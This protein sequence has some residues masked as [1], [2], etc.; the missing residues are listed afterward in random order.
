M[1]LS[2]AIL[3]SSVRCSA[4]PL[5][6]NLDL[7][8]TA[9]NLAMPASQAPVGIKVGNVVKTVAPGSAVTPAEYVA[10]QQMLS[11]GSQSLVVTAAGAASGGSF[12]TSGLGSLS[13]ADLIVP[14][15]VMAVHDFGMA[16]SLNIAGT[17]NNSGSL[18]GLS[19]NTAVTAG[20]INA[21]NIFNNLGA[22]IA[23]VRN[24]E[25]TLNAVKNIVNAGRIASAGNL[26][27]NAGGTITNSGVIEAINGNLNINS[28][29]I[30]NSGGVL[31]A[32]QGQINVGNVM[33]TVKADLHLNGG[34]LIAK[35]VNLVSKGTVQLDVN[36]L[37][38]VLNITAGAAHVAAATSNL[39]LGKM[40]IDGDPTYFNRSGSV[41]LHGPLQ[42][43]GQ[44]LAIVARDDIVTDTG[45]GVISTASDTQ[46]G[47]SILMVAGAEFTTDGGDSGEGV[48]N[49]TLTITGPSA[50]GGQINLAGTV[51]ITTLSSSK[52]VNPGNGGDI[53]L[54]AFG[55][56]VTLPS[57]LV[58]QTGGNGS[59][60]NGSVTIMAG[61]TS[62]TA[63][64]GGAVDTTGGTGGG[65]NVSVHAVQPII[66][67]S[68]VVAADGSIASGT[69]EAGDVQPASVQMGNINSSGSLKVVAGN[70]L[71]VNA[72]STYTARAGNLELAAPNIVLGDA[73]TIRNLGAGDIKFTSAGLPLP[74]TVLAPDGGTT[75]ISTAGGSIYFTPTAGQSLDLS[76]T[77]GSQTAMLNLTGGPVFATVQAGKLHLAENV[78]LQ[79]DGVF[80]AVVET[81]GGII[82]IAFEPFVGTYNGTT[83]ASNAAS[84]GTSAPADQAFWG[85]WMTLSNAAAG[86][87]GVAD[88][89]TISPTGGGSSSVG[90][91][92]NFIATYGQGTNDFSASSPPA[93]FPVGLMPIGTF[94]DV[95]TGAPCGTPSAT[96]QPYIPTANYWNTQA[97]AANGMKIAAGVTALGLNCPNGN[98]IDADGFNTG[99]TLLEAQNAINIA[100]QYPGTVTEVVIGNEMIFG[101]VTIG[102]LITVMNQAKAYRDSQGFQGT[103]PTQ[104]NYLPITTRQRWDVLAGI[105]NPNTGYQPQLT[106]LLTTVA[107]GHVYG[108]MY[109]YFDQI[110]SLSQSAT[111]QNTT[112][113]QFQSS[114]TTSMTNQLTAW[115]NAF[116][117]AGI[118]LDMRIG[119]TGWPT[120]GAGAGGQPAN[121]AN[122]TF[123]QWY[124]QAMQSW[125]TNTTVTGKPAISTIYFEGYDEP[126]KGPPPSSSLLSEAYF[127]LFT[128][129]GTSANNAPFGGPG[130]TITGIT[131]KFPISIS[132][133]QDRFLHIEGTIRAATVN[134]T[135]DTVKN[136]GEI[137][138]LSGNVL[139]NTKNLMN[140]GGATIATNL[141]TGSITIQSADTLK[142]TGTGS[143]SNPAGVGGPITISAG[144]S[145]EFG[146]GASQQFLGGDNVTIQSPMVI[147]PANSTATISTDGGA[148]N[149]LS[150]LG[151]GILFSKTSGTGLATLSLAGGPVS[152]L[153]QA[154]G[155]YVD[156]GVELRSDNVFT[157]NVETTGGI[158]G[159]AFQPFVGVY[160]GNVL[161]SNA[162][163][164]GTSAPAGQGFWGSWMTLSNAAGGSNGVTDLF[165]IQPTLPGG[166]N[167]TVVKNFGFIATYGQGTNDFS[168]SSPPA[169]HAVPLM[170]IGTLY[171]VNTGAPCGSLS[172]TCQAYIPT[173]NYWNIQAA[174]TNGMKISAGVNTI[175]LQCPGGV[176]NDA[177]GFNKGFTL[178][179][180]KHAIDMAKKYPGT[181]SEL[182]I[183][184]EMIFGPVTI[185]DLIT[186]MNQA[187]TYRDQQGF[188]GTDPTRANYLPITTRQKWD[189]LAGVNNHGTGYQPQLKSLLQ[190]V[191]EGHV[192]G[193]MYAYFDPG[194]SL[195]QNATPTNTTKTQFQTSVTTSMTSQLSAW[196]NS[197]NGEG[198][199]IEKRIGET[200]W[201]SAGV[202][203][204]GQ[205]A[206]WGN[207]DFAKWYFEAMQTWTTN[208]TVSGVP[209]IKAIYFEGFDEPIKGPANGSLSE[210]HF[211]LFTA[212]GTSGTNAPFGAPGFTITGIT[213]KFPF[214]LSSVESRLLQVNG[215]IEANAVNLM[216]QNAN[217]NGSVTAT[218]GNVMMQN[219]SANTLMN[220]N[221]GIGS[222]I[223]AMS[224]GG[225]VMF[226]PTTSGAM[227]VIGFGGT[228]NA[229]G[230]VSFNGGSGQ[231][232]VRVGAITGTVVSNGSPVSIVTLP[233]SSVSATG[234]TVVTS[235][236]LPA[237]V[238]PQQ[239]FSSLSGT[240]VIA[241]DKTPQSHSTQEPASV[242]TAF[243][244]RKEISQDGA[245]IGVLT[246]Q[247]VTAKSDSTVQTGLG[248]VHV[249]AGATT[250]VIDNGDSIA[251][252]NLNDD[253]PGAVKVVAGGKQISL[254]PGQ[255]L[256]LTKQ[257]GGEFSKVNPAA[258]VAY[259]NNQRFELNDELTG[260]VADFSIPSAFAA[261]KQLHDL[262]RS[263]NDS[264]RKL[265]MQIMKNA[266]ILAVTNPV[267]VPFSKSGK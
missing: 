131:Q 107:E 74:L 189:V 20:T 65:G 168:A 233:T 153:T 165:T 102:D 52:L 113:T 265:A 1:L 138:A 206:N 134:L 221:M 251:V 117:G 191:A 46:D 73:T 185:G 179:E 232:T 101:P 98:C 111:P 209:A 160:N 267:A 57:N 203:A 171:D 144:R 95:N 199:T 71:V 263:P 33:P 177:A 40:L 256:V 154:A 59:G 262:L 56:K 38:G 79:S 130:F 208:T 180:A 192:Y 213:Q 112:Q 258:G 87:N 214:T 6:V 17:L 104:A 105:N 99:F 135:A 215:K 85:S 12:S 162:A 28:N 5:P 184:N 54:V 23:S 170:P 149:F 90:S 41:T 148:I 92:F 236:G 55:G 195:A 116:N 230:N 198:I 69:F 254:Q 80:T 76:K 234:T 243:D 16:R 123:A 81:A 64:E 240:T 186:V 3:C 217:I 235:E 96:C 122:T 27:L 49:T 128:V 15:R 53:R 44:A 34:N 212:T 158:I 155:I 187:K 66:N 183:G 169:P 127:G 60:T 30:N 228:I 167:G 120:A 63:I 152:A 266:A 159:I 176:C 67:G 182:V 106:T 202:G 244:V 250:F 35:E 224:A 88:L 13:L 32:L 31:Q 252:F 100:K 14:S 260:Y 229:K 118:T 156:S 193:N 124:F 61:A 174:A 248:T 26:N 146:P 242:E 245:R 93:P 18:Y 97:A 205:P 247:L 25:L 218:A 157:A 82:G 141:A 225:N 9:P 207:T 108:N 37:Q 133:V 91:L 103:D 238:V 51:P 145:I 163:S 72:S 181:V 48:T 175:G 161:A 255:Q 21:T 164:F 86:S 222:S 19:T 227:S 253:K 89:F 58:I 239:N 223:N 114:V 125:T 36:E 83:L 151:H 216:S 142:I 259:R 62:G 77:S 29:W 126:W 68:V 75:N 2:V 129:T 147:A 110:L 190:T 241:T 121:W 204:G 150:T 7:T 188:Q 173:A 115:Y 197:F 140:S 261:A 210:A 109:A 50:N 45:A 119:E 264:D 166:G 246:G 70:S 4:E 211:G 139:I 24:L 137:T 257:K 43:A 39:N 220:V 94:Y 200:G 10:A 249:A 226:N 172:A 22:T 42:F 47:G 237:L 231:V 11:M 8:S 201:P 178:V 196:Y 78:L 132:S 219:N 194:L 136:M 143:I 84:L